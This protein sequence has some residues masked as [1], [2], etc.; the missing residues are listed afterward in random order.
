MTVFWRAS[1]IILENMQFPEIH[2]HLQAAGFLHASSMSKGY[3]LDLQLIN[4]LVE[5]W[6]P[7][8]H[9]FHLLCGECTIMIEDVALQL[10]LLV[11]GPI[12]TGS[13]IVLDKVTLYRAYIMRLI[14]GI[15]MPDKS[16]IL[17]H[18][19]WLLHLVDF[20]DCG[21]LSL[22]LVVLSTLY[23][24]MCRATNP[25][26]KHRLSYVGLPKVLEDIKFLLDQWSKVEMW[27]ANVS[28]L[29]YTMEE[30]HKIDWVLR[31]FGWRQQISPPLQDLKDMHKVD[32][33]GKDH[34]DW[35]M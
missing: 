19:K 8:T 27:D 31:Q 11:D 6:R 26:W 12:I 3:K 35:S 4:T 34:I 7:E 22:G 33:R 1:S 2:G 14:G 21:K 20:N 30:I 16:H 15:L 17:M 29:L 9:T 24:E 18:V 25:R 13:G 32:M 5:R 10:G 23:R 28:L